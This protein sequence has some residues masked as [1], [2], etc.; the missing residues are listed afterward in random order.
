MRRFLGLLIVLQLLVGGGY[1]VNDEYG[2]DISD[3]IDELRTGT[4]EVPAAVDDPRSDALPT[5]LRPDQV[6]VT[7]TLTQL[8]ADHAVSDPL[9]TPFTIEATERGVTRAEVLNAVINKRKTIVHWDGGRPLPLAGNGRIDLGPSNVKVQRDAVV[10]TLEGAPRQLVAG[11]YR[12]GTTVAVG[13]SGIATPRDG[14]VFD[15]GQ[16][17][18]LQVSKGG[19]FIRQPPREVRLQ[20]GEPGTV[21]FAGELTVR[22]SERTGKLASVRFGPGLYDIR[23]TPLAGG[24]RVVALLQGPLQA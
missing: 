3:R 16:G 13:T 20:A 1:L 23:L 24:Y 9:P 19:A 5:R 8:V 22:T 12:V 2:D 15:G 4:S 11:T 10:W 6:E 17:T 14:V 21:T 7:G 18:V